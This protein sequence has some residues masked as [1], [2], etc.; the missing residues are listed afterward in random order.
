MNKLGRLRRKAGLTLAAVMM[1]TG[2]AGVPSLPVN[3]AATGTVTCTVLNVRSGCSTDDSVITTVTKGTELEVISAEGDWYAVSIDGSTGY[4]SAQYVSMD[5]SSGAVPGQKG[6]VNVGALNLREQASTDSAVVSL[7]YG[8][9]TVEITESDDGW[10]GVVT[11]SGAKGYVFAQYITVGAAGSAQTG[12]S[13]SSTDVTPAS[14]EGVCNTTALNVRSDASTDASLLGYITYG[15]KVTI[16]GTAGSWYKVSAV[17]D[18]KSITGFVHGDYI[19]VSGSEGSGEQN[20]ETAPAS[21]E[22]VCN[23]SALNVRKEAST[24]S[25]TYGLIQ[26]GTKVTIL[27]KSGDWY[28]VKTVVEGSEVTGYA[29]ASYI[30]VSGGAQSEEQSTSTEA[31]SGTGV[32]TTSVL[33]LRKEAS[34]SSEVLGYIRKDEKV[35]ITG[36][37]G[38]WYQ[39]TASIDG[40]AVNGYAHKDYIKV[41]G[42]QSG[43][44]QNQ[45][46]DV[47]ESVWATTAVNIRK[48]ANTSSGIITVLAKNDSVTR[49]GVVSNGW[50]RVDFNGQTGYIHNDYITT[51]NPNPSENT[52]PETPE[53]NSEEQ[54]PEENTNQS[55]TEETKPE[56]SKPETNLPPEGSS[57][58]TGV[59]GE[60]IAA[61]ALQWVGYP[62]VWGGNN[63]ST[64]VD[65]SGFTQQVYLHYGISLNRSADAQKVNGIRIASPAEAKAGDLFF[66][67]SSSYADHV[68]LY[69]GEGTVVHASSPSVGIIVSPVNYRTPIAIVRVIY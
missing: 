16:S 55:Q 7:L 59:T 14:G 49:T 67:G 22:G 4:V 21:G 33:N 29:H 30:T 50:S 51:V 68:A 65:C 25:D 48:E 31:V 15:T 9:E 47:N 43:S 44:G 63:L 41:D 24:S 13:E 34:T 5:G 3:A 45:I 57:G 23:T 39:V 11:A 35:M 32:C 62:Y 2:T 52:Q 26:K 66:Y 56:E 6:A 40:A 54:K 42:S 18:G 20:T 28:Q 69:T 64:G 27:G 19:T 58:I 61:Y 60:Q 38:S 53:S 46:I 17:M 37:Q 8:G 12:S 10:Y 36:V 1:L